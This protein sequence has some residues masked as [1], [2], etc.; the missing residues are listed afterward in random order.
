M[1]LLEMCL[2]FTTEC[3]KPK[4]LQ[5][6][7]FPAISV[8]LF[9]VLL[10]RRFKTLK[11][12]KLIMH[13]AFWKRVAVFSFKID[14]DEWDFKK[15][16]VNVSYAKFLKNRWKNENVQQRT[17]ASSSRLFEGSIAVSR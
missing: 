4:S 8:Q 14:S 12:N 16:Q 5:S 9:R 13:Y 6:V 7:V 1:F 10:L 2:N 17:N 3:R 15:S 11:T